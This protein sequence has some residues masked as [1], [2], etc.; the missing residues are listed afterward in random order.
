MTYQ[1]FDYQ[2]VVAE[3]I[4]L[5]RNQE[6]LKRFKDN[7]IKN[8]KSLLDLP[9][10][11]DGEAAEPISKE[12]CAK[13]ENWLFDIAEKLFAES[14]LLEIPEISPVSNGGLDIEW[15]NLY[16]LL[17]HIE[18]QGAYYYFDNGERQKILK[19]DFY[20]NQKII[21]NILKEYFSSSID[22]NFT[23]TR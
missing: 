15:D 12:I 21:F 8:N 13:T 16:R 6:S 7:I 11:W 17:I 10:D 4:S 3:E 18:S 20:S 5:Y 2:N 23:Y 22:E 1:G 14:K 19:G 9:K